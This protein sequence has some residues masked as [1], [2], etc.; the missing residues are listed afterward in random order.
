MKKVLKA[1]GNIVT[2]ALFALCIWIIIKSTLAA[3]Q[4][5]PAF[6]FNYAISVVA[7]DSMV[8]TFKKD[9]LIIYKKID[10]IDVQI[11]DI[12]VFRDITDGKSITHRVVSQES[13]NPLSYITQGDANDAPLRDGTLI[14]DRITA[15]NLY[16]KVIHYGSFL[17]IGKLVNDGRGILFIL[18]II[19]FLILALME[20][21]NIYLTLKKSKEEEI[22]NKMREELKNQ[23]LEE[24]LIE[25]IKTENSDTNDQVENSDD[26]S[27]HS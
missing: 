5:R 27:D 9:D 12:V 3:K 14:I 19:G 15:E 24:G 21:K 10:I 7:S 26:T 17:G 6:Y 8:P 2:V 4:N 13:V 18:V 16:G 22:E 1:I 20:V 25:D 11:G 23:L